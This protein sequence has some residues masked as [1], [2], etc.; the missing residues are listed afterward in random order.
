MVVGFCALIAALSG[1]AVA[2]PGK[3]KVDSGDIKNGQV[4]AADIAKKAVTSTKIR[5]NAVTAS[6]VKD[7]ALTGADIDEATLG[8]VP[9]A[10][11]AQRATTAGS[12]GTSQDAGKLGGTSAAAVKGETQPFSFGIS[13]GART[14][15]TVGPL[16]LRARCAEY[17][18]P[19]FYATL[20]VATSAQNSTLASTFRPPQMDF[21][22]SDG[23]VEVN[24]L[25]ENSPYYDTFFGGFSAAAPDGSSMTL[26]QHGLGNDPF[27][28]GPHCYFNGEVVV[29][30]PT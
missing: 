3:S 16:T 10:G 13:G 21:D 18:A 9:A 2:L 1:T 12:A 14:I 11:S 25:A 22:P 19:Q 29:T 24:E 26:G 8:S 4:K 17:V 28:G 30:G 23:F 7:G 20:Q 15:A 27:P 6:K 5:R